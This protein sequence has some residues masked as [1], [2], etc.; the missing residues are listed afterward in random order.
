MKNISSQK[1][2]VSVIIPTF[3]RGHIIARSVDSVLAQ[4]FTDYE[5]IVV[6][7]GSTDNTGEFLKK[8]Y[9]E[10]IQY[11]A[12][13]VNMGLANARNRG[14]EA[15]R[16]TYIA[17][18]DDDDLWFP[19]K[20]AL[21][22][23]LL[24]K[25]PELSL[26]YCGTVKVNSRG[27]WIE[28]IR[29]S[30]RGQIFEAM[31]YQNCL[32]GPASVAIFP[33]AVLRTSGMFDAGLSSCAD[34]DL[35][36]RM[37][38]CGKV[39]FVDRPLVQYVIHEC[40]MHGDI[41]GMAKD[42]FVILDK[43]LPLVEQGGES[44]D[45]R[46][47][48]YSNHLIHFAWQYYERNDIPQFRKLIFQA[49]E[50][51]PSNR[52]PIRGTALR[53]RETLA[54]ETLREYWSISGRGKGQARGTVFSDHYRQLAWEYYRQDDMENFRR[55]VILACRYSFPQMPLRLAVPFFKSFLGK[56]IADSVHRARKRLQHAGRKAVKQPADSKSETYPDITQD[57]RT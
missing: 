18:L 26:V 38:R 48:I 32:L 4:T 50:R 56:G 13:P 33:R 35:W 49:L 19:E 23:E 17:I 53:K 22:V 28:E 43:Y 11:I 15:S 27:E 7:D 51:D 6:D 8:H 16:G 42:T 14:I 52:F 24:E 55:C 20:L 31:L 29:P 39:D 54:L 44:A 25:E 47:S 36:V 1:P 46:K 2:L 21:Q 45:P 41:S 57:I 9:G 37:A 5:I 10:R 34:W 12:Q 40:N 30:R 3:N